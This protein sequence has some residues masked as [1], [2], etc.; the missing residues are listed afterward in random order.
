[1]TPIFSKFQHYE[2]GEASN[3]RQSIVKRKVLKRHMFLHDLRNLVSYCV[4]IYKEAY[5][6]FFQE[7]SENILKT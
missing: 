4:H 7:D 5:R 1:M 2:C 6:R 3:N